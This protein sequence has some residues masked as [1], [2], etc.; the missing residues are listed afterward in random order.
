MGGGSEPLRLAAAVYLSL[1]GDNE[2]NLQNEVE[3]AP[4]ISAITF[5]LTVFLAMSEFK[6]SLFP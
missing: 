5:V 1:S 6:A 4:D 2:M 3:L